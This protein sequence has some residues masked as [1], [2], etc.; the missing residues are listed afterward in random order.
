MDNLITDVA[1]V[2]AGHAQDKA[3]ASGVTAILFDAPAVTAVEVRGGA[4][5]G[6]CVQF[7]PEM[8]VERADAI[9]LSGGSAFGL[10]ATGGAMA[11]LRERGRGFPIGGMHVPIVAQAIV[12]DLLNGGDKN[13]GRR[14][15]YEELGH[16]A[17]AAAGKR[18]PLGSVGGGLGATTVNLKGGVGSA[19]TKVG[20][21][22][23]GAVA[24]VNAIASAVVGQGPHFWAAPFEQG[25]EF[26]GRGLP[27]SVSA[28]DLAPVW[29]AARN[30]APPSRSSPPTPRSPPPRPSGSPSWPTA[31]SPA[32]CASPM[33]RST[34]TRCSPR[35][36][37]E[38]RSPIRSRT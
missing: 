34:A 10:D 23:V 36:P 37:G 13:W 2:S 26:G 8:T 30:P 7:A 21:F 9:L 12:F 29:K 25:N 4:P 3:L 24:I 16:A 35:P 31:G 18:F 19:S 5:A 22:T 20:P 6:R 33:R 15:P 11:F 32:R 27:R 28:E 17:C 38:C 14:S 1:G